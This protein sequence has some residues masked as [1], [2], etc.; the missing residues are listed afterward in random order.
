MISKKLIEEAKSR[1]A[2]SQAIKWLEK[3][4]RSFEEL[5]SYKIAW[6]EWAVRNVCSPSTRK[7]YE[8]VIAPA[9]K[10]YCEAVASAWKAYCEAIAPAWKVYDEATAP[11]WKVYDEATAS[12]LKAY[13]EAAASA[14]L[15][16]LKTLESE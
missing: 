6:A 16:A 2:C 12:A 14:L 3:S 15:I 11:A 1:K 7:A 8:D 5:I 9:W 4:P 10:A 13:C